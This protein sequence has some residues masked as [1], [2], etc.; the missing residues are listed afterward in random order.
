ML[1]LVQKYIGVV[2]TVTRR[3]PMAFQQTLRS[4]GD[5]FSFAL[6]H[7]NGV[8]GTM[9]MLL[10]DRERRYF[11]CT[12]SGTGEGESHQRVRWGK[13]L[14]SRGTACLSGSAATESG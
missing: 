7:D 3:F 1:D 4:P 5:W 13:P 11:I 14:P 12:A 2:R 10:R 6:Y 9:A 8:I